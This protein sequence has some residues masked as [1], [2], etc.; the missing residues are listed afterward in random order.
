[1]Y[2]NK[3]ALAIHFV[4]LLNY[5]NHIA[6]VGRSLEYYSEM[7]IH[8]FDLRYRCWKKFIMAFENSLQI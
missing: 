8:L 3:V 4:F 1:L 6:G 5:N 7:P 2:I